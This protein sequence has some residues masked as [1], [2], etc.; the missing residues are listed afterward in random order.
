M[1]LPRYGLDPSKVRLTYNPE[2]I[3]ALAASRLDELK[4]RKEL[5]LE[6]INEMRGALPDR[7]DVDGG[8]AILV[9]AS[10]VP[11]AAISVTEDVDIEDEVRR[12]TTE[13]EEES[14]NE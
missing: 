5:G 12:I 4:T 6:T 9:P 11:I 1:V 8:D 3:P 13:P 14:E 7:E 10:M 2:S